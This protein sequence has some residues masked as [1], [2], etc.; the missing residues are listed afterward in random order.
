[1][2]TKLLVISIFT[3]TTNYLMGYAPPPKESPAL[4]AARALHQQIVEKEKIV[5]DLD[6]EINRYEDQLKQLTKNLDELRTLRAQEQLRLH[7][8]VQEQN[9]FQAPETD[10]IRAQTARTLQPL[11]PQEQRTPKTAENGWFVSMMNIINL[12][13][14]PT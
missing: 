12:Y 8:L 13:K 1:M 7:A 10:L 6:S 4:L 9:T 11:A 2:N 14:E 3:L 5:R